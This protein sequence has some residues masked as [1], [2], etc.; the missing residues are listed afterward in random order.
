MR[1]KEESERERGRKREN[2]NGTSF[3]AFNLCAIVCVFGLRFRRKRIFTCRVRP[4]VFCLPIMACARKP[5]TCVIYYEN[6][7]LALRI[8]YVYVSLSRAPSNKLS[9]IEKLRI[10]LFPRNCAASGATIPSFVMLWLVSNLCFFSAM[11]YALS[12]SPG[13]AC[14]ARRKVQLCY[15]YEKKAPTM[16]L[17]AL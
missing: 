12:F 10:S 9:R 6:G 2:D 11:L 16:L 17:Y 1:K 15:F 13:H 7:T 4:Q 8:F 3:L 14:Y 5:R